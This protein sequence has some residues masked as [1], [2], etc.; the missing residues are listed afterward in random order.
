MITDKYITKL[1]EVKEKFGKNEQGKF[2]DFDLQVKI[3]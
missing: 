2:Y 3:A 1:S